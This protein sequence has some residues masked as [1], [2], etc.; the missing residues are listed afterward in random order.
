MHIWQDLDLLIEGLSR[1]FV[2]KQKNIFR[3]YYGQIL[4]ETKL[5]KEDIFILL[6]IAMAG[7]VK[8]SENPFYKKLK[9]QYGGKI[10][11]NEIIS[12]FYSVV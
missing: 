11:E 4:N 7:P 8:K 10:P 9:E 3:N 6:F 12:K 2:D 5:N 1:P